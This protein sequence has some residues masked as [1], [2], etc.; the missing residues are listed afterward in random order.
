MRILIAT[1]N[2]NLVGGVEMYLQ[3]VIPGLLGRGHQV[4]LL[5]ENSFSPKLKSIDP[6]AAPLPAWCPTEG[7]TAVAMLSGAGWQPDVVYS[8]GLE[9]GSLEDALLGGYPTVLYGHNYYGT[10]ISGR[11][12]HSFPR[13]TPCDRQFGSAC[14]VLYYPRR[15]GGLHPATMWAMFRRQSQLNSQL[16]QFQSILVASKHM[17]REF[18]KHGVRPDNLQIVP[19]PT[20]DIL[21]QATAPVQKIPQ[22]RILFIGRLTD[23]KGA[24]Y[25]IRA[26]PQAASKIGRPLML[27]I[28]GDGPE[29]L[30][31]QNLAVRVGIKVEFTGWLQTDRKLDLLRQADL[32]AVPSLWP[33]PFGLVGIEAG[34]LGLPAVGYAVGGIP[35]WLKPGQSGELAPSDPPTVEGLAEAM[36]RVLADA[37]HYARLCR[38]AW[39]TAR[40]FTLDAH[41]ATL[42]P[43]LRAAKH[44]PA[45]DSYPDGERV[46]A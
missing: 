39:E 43:V 40:C 38:G 44:T 16:R 35:E 19:L 17:Q 4:A 18:Q 36:V 24:D 27:T 12:C 34:C 9:D 21:P 31:L 10:C 37:D 26:I 7:G 3:A 29:R 28:A 41:L 22:G 30:K 42:E 46:H 11:K 2:R 32:L 5:Y 15:C 25:L 45:A 6:P 23:L 33:E 13:A 1:Q 14:L 20:T 8:Q